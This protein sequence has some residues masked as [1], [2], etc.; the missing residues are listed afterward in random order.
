MLGRFVQNCLMT[1]EGVMAKKVID[2]NQNQSFTNWV[3]EEHPI[4]ISKNLFYR[5]YKGYCKE[6]LCK[7]EKW[8]GQK[9]KSSIKQS[10]RR[11]DL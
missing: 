7:V 9:H 6:E 5:D 1:D 8:W 10:Y 2:L 4:E 11:I 3:I